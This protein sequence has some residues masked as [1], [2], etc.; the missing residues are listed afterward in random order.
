MEEKVEYYMIEPNLKQIYGKK[1]DK[2]TKFEEKTEDGRVHQTFKNLTLTTIIDDE[3]D[4]G[5]YKVKEHS[6]ISITVPDGTVLIWSE[7]EGFIVPQVQV[8]TLEE[9]EDKI[10][11]FKEIYSSDKEELKNDVRGNERT[12]L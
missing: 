10:K 2:N 9:L 5:I 6:E 1:V 3:R 7:L 12:S 11:D 8:C 4:Q